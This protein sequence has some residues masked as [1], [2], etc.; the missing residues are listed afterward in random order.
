[1]RYRGH[2]TRAIVSAGVFGGLGTALPADMTGADLKAFLSGKTIYLE[3]TE[4]SATGTPGQGVIYWA[5]NGKAL[6]KTPSGAVWHGI[7]EINGNTICA[8]WNERPTKAC[9]RYD[10]TGHA[11]TVIDA[12]S[13]HQRGIVV[14]T[15]VGNAEKL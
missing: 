9:V 8:D 1:V 6:Y 10:K 4:A 2:V 15:A 3:L 13:G 5:D 12:S 14:K 7:W 11:I